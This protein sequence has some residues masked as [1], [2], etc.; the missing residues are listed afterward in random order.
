MRAQN[1]CEVSTGRM[2]MSLMT[3]ENMGR[4]LVD[5]VCIEI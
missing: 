1:E 5:D 3:I 4:E 2:R